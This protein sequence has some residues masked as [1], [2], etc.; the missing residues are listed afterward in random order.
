MTS[1][2]F[3]ASGEA[4]PRLVFVHE[5]GGSLESWDSVAA[6]LEGDHRLLRY[7]LRGASGSSSP[8]TLAD[9]VTDLVALVDEL[10][11][12][13]PLHLVSCAAGG[14]VTLAFARRHPDRVASLVLCA[15]AI[16]TDAPRRAYLEN[17]AALCR[18]D[19]MAA[20]AEASLDRSYPAECR[21]DAAL[22]A[23]YRARF[24][25]H[26]PADYAEANLLL[27]RTDMAE[28]IAALET[29][30]LLLAGTL[31][32]LRPPDEVRRLASSFRRASI[33]TV[34]SGHIMPVHAP[35]A[36]GDHI[37]R[38]TAAHPQPQAARLQQALS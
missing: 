36:V 27:A 13:A 1:L 20:I 2:R 16:T 22:F 32:P 38:F 10:G 12:A 14:L 30:C 17:R 19:G 35:E 25:S 28:T 8:L 4:G 11:F 9:H 15:P 21:G 33:A 7:D 5:L 6:R 31:D 3:A 37:R 34:T 26:N 18:R 24:L 23:A 29:P